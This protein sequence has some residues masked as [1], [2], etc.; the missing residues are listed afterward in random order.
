MGTLRRI[1]NAVIVGLAIVAGVMMAA[2]FLMIVLDVV[3]RTAG[4]QPPLF[5]S[6]LSEYSLLYMTMFAAPWVVR[7]K[8]HVY[9]ESLTSALPERA[10]RL[11]ER[12][13]LV[14]CIAVCL[15]LAYYAA[16]T[17][18]GIAGR[19]EDDVRSIVI[20]RW[21]LFVPLPVGFTL[22]AGEFLRFL[23]G[24]DHMLTGKRGA[25]VDV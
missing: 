3:M 21:V 20:P 25:S 6:A 8:G 1:Y 11:I 16:V 19:G 7:I 23:L 4:S 15:V 10:R 24:F 12:G 9:V 18:I 13:V 17:G 5:V 22:C 2:V 14:L